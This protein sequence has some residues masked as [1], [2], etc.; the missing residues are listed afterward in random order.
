MSDFIIRRMMGLDI[1]GV[2]A[3][4]Q[5][6]FTTPWSKGAFESEIYDNELTYYLVV[7]DKES[8]KVIGYAGMWVI[9]DEAHVTNIAI[10]P[11]YQGNGI[12]EI[13][14]RNLM[15]AAIVRG[16]SCM[17]LEVRKSNNVAQGLYTKLGFKARGVRPKYYSDTKED[18]LIMWCDSLL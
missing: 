15:E 14:V 9:V 8:K 12:G 11:D 4:E 7:I 18:A 3:V 5:A 2:L 6:T 16:A 10:S 13:L 17:T 1:E